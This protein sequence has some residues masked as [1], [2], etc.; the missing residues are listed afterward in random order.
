MTLLYLVAAWVSGIFLAAQST[1][2]APV[3]LWLALAG[4]AL[5]L[6]YAVRRRPT[7]R[8]ALICGALLAL[9]AARTTWAARPLPAEHI[10]HLADGRYLTLTGLVTQPPDPR[11]SYTGL[12]VRVEAVRADGDERLAFGEVLVHA[13]RYGEYAYGDRVRVS[14]PLLTPPQF[15]D[16]SYRDY[17]ARRGVYAIVP[18]ARVEVLAHKQGAPWLA[19]LYALRTRAQTVITR[20][21]PSPQAPLLSGILLGVESGIP[22]DVRDAFNRTGTTHVIAISGANMIVVIGALMGLLTPALGKRRAGWVALGGVAL[23]TLFVGA[24]AAVVRAA[25]MG[26]LSVLAWQLGRRTYGLT[27]L[28][29]TVWLMSLWRPFVLW[30]VGFQLSVAATAGLVLFG[31]ALTGGLEALLQRGFAHDTA[32]A[33]TR[34]LAEPLTLGLAAQFTTTP[35]ILLHFGRLSAISLLANLLIA[36]A[37]PYIMTLGALAVGV[38]LVWGAAGEVAAWAVWLP[39]SWTL[40][41]VRNLGTLRWAS[42]QVDFPASSTWAAYA[43]LGA[44][45]W[46]AVQHPDDRAAWLRALRRKVSTAALLSAGAVLTVLVWY[47]ALHQPDGRLHVWFLDVGQGHAVLLQTPNG[48]HILIDGGD[49]P[50][51]LRRA[52]GDVLPFWDRSLALV[53]VTQPKRSAIHALPALLTRYEVSAALTNGHAAENDAYTALVAAWQRADVPVQVVTAG[54]RV[55]TDDGV[56]LEMLHPQSVPATDDEPDAVGMVL[57]VRYGQATFLLA[58]EINAEAEDV[59]LA[60]GWYVGSAVLELPAHGKAAANPPDFLAAVR[61]QVGVVG[62]AAGNRAGLPDAETVQAIE[63]A[64]GRALYRTDRHGTVE[65]VTDGRTLWIYT[66][67]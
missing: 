42:L 47:A 55:Q 6:A 43:G 9:G 67:R 3:V 41:V 19:A 2:R 23:Y 28:A 40:A 15:D 10:A 24:G 48:A 21:L 20:A 27:T 4:A 7:W 51:T 5:T 54:A 46:L 58:P 18:N 14:G 66:A 22:A 35:L 45:G 60:A 16:F 49:A 30:D 29:F 62:V 59:M 8:L 38:G 44:L 1:A 11:D 17:L 50:N 52:V 57:R 63:Q 37:Q 56:T 36:P 32:R 31:D 34:W 61:P 53:I 25:I 33:L 13:P 65:M 39:L 26:G 12:R 64:T